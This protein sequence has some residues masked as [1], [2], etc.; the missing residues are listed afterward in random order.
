MRRG[1]IVAETNPS[2]TPADPPSEPRVETRRRISLIWAIPIVAALIAA[3]LGYKTLSEQGPTITITF[4][5]ASGLE[6]GKTR[7]KHK[8]VEVGL[9]RSV[10]LSPDLQ[11]VIVVADMH[12]EVGRH[13]NANARFWVIRP[14]LGTAGVS[15]LETIISGA[16][17]EMEPGDGG[18]RKKFEGLEEPP[19]VQ[20]DVPGRE[21]LLRASKAGSLGPHSPVFFRGVKVGEVLGVDYTTIQTEVIVHVFVQAPFDKHVYPGSRFWNASGIS[22]GAGPQGFRIQIESLQAILAGG[23]AFDTAESARFG[24]A[25]AEKTSFVLYDDE[26][27]VVEIGLH[28]QGPLSALFRRLGA[29]A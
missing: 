14:R 3:W 10:E 21:F 1:A 4:R 24:E 29:W 7:V 26:Q 17:I 27:A 13:L 6:A 25:A 18:S 19:V 12:K 11:Q 20:S 22:F 15:G 2:D 5:T 23:I 8:D 28:Y 9:V 16:Y